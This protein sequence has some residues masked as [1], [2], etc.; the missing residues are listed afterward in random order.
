MPVYFS[1]EGISGETARGAVDAFAQG[2]AA[3][4]EGFGPFGCGEASGLQAI[5]VDWSSGWGG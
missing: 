4:A 5:D 3:D 2:L 1:N